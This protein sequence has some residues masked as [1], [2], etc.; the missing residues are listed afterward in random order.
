MLTTHLYEP[1]CFVDVDK[2][3]A[4]REV[5]NLPVLNST[6]DLHNRLQWHG[7]Q[8]VVFAIPNI[9]QDRREELYR[10]YQEMGYKIKAY[11]TPQFGEKGR[12]HDFNI[13]DGSS[14]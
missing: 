7:V 12:L 5:Y 3:K 6:D 1:V 4:G 2:Q 14:V 13:E 11:D 10:T 9:P 8:E